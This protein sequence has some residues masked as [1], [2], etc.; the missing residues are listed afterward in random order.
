MLFTQITLNGV[1]AHALNGAIWT[2][3]PHGEQVNGNVYPEP[4]PNPSFT[5]CNAQLAAVGLPAAANAKDCVFLNGGPNGP[6]GDGLADG[7]YVFMVTA[8]PGSDNNLEVLLSNDAAQCRRFTASNGRISGVVVTGSCEHKTGHDHDVGIHGSAKTIQLNRAVSGGGDKFDDTPNNGGVYKTWITSED[9][10]TGNGGNLSCVP[11]PGNSP[12]VAACRAANLAGFQQGHTKTDNFKVRERLQLGCI[13]G[14]KYHDHNA[15]GDLDTGEEG[16][17]GWTIQLRSGSNGTGTVLATDVSSATGQFSF[18]ERQEGT[19]TV[20]EV[21]QANWLNTDPTDA[22]VPLVQPAGTTVDPKDGYY[23]VTLTKSSGKVSSAQDLRFGNIQLNEIRGRKFYDSNR[24]GASRDEVS[25]PGWRIE[26]YQNGVLIT[27]TYTNASGE[28][29]FTGLIP[30]TYL[31]CEVLPDADWVQT[32]PQNTLCSALNPEAPGGHR[33]TFP[34]HA[35]DGSPQPPEVVTGKNFG[36]ICLIPFEGG[37]TWGYWKT[38]S[39]TEA[40]APE[41]PKDPTY[42]GLAANPILI[43]Q[44]IGR[45]LIVNSPEDADLVFAADGSLDEPSQTLPGEIG[46]LC[47]T[48]NGADCRESEFLPPADSSGDCHELL[49]AQ[50]LALKLN[51]RKFA[52][53][54][55]AT[56]M[57][58]GDPN[59]G[60]TV[61]EVIA[62]ADAALT[63]WFNGGTPDLC[64][65][66]LTVNTIN[67]NESVPVLFTPSPTLCPFTTPY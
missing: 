65:L 42:N 48:G 12:T 54:G 16:L 44:A 21:L 67:E 60:L 7:T 10:Y 22:D 51:V 13:V 52:G 9:D 24:D 33:E 11:G 37:L 5:D 46:N 26:L 17:S 64:S 28:Y 43:G 1:S 36:N 31:V 61:D 56:Y 32:A 59:S 27:T 66:R 49:S 4:G 40:T 2:S 20:N 30:G 8:P 6:G 57:N 39:G 63:S 14:I 41:A 45:H 53:M 50:L 55:S 34:L 3:Y 58:A 38:H 29:A 35:G 47:S 18:C 19:Y 62:L 23:I 15:D 25:I